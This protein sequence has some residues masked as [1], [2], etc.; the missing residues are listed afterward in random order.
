MPERNRFAPEGRWDL[1]VIC[2]VA[3]EYEISNLKWPL[4]MDELESGL[5]VWRRGSKGRG[6]DDDDDDDD[7]EALPVRAEYED[8]S[9]N[10][11]IG[12]TI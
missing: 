7:D 5:R 1:D 8:F 2:F 11:R 10:R 12:I 3:V 6:L 4:L 9:F